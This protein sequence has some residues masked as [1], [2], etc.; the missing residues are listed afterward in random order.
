MV[1]DTGMGI[2]PDFLPHI[3]DAFRQADSA[4]NR[5]ARGLGLGL[6]IVRR[7]VEAH[8]GRIEAES[9]GPGRGSTFRL[10][11]PITHVATAPS[12]ATE[13]DSPGWDS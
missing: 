5:K 1:V 12:D 8:N 10:S 3:F 4:E 13:S 2:A 7:I 9:E 11:L 6:N